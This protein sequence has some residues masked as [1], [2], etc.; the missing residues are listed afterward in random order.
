MGILRAINEFPIKRLNR[1]TLPSN[2]ALRERCEKFRLAPGRA[3]EESGA[4]VFRILAA[5]SAE[6]APSLGSHDLRFI[7]A[8][9]GAHALISTGEVRAILAELKRRREP[10]LMRSAFR[11]LLANYRQ[12]NLRLMLRA[13]VA[14]HFS[15]LPASARRFCEHSGILREDGAIE[16]VCEQITDAA[17]I[18][19]FCLSMGLNSSAL[20]TGYGIEVRLRT[21]RMAVERSEVEELDKLLKWSFE[22]ING[23][24]L[25][26]YYAAVLEPFEMRPPPPDVQKLLMA[27]LVRKFRDPRIHQWPS[28][29]GSEGQS[30][31]AIC[32][33]TIKKWLSIEYLDLF[34]QIIQATAVDAQ[35]NPRKQFWLKYFEKGVISDLTL[36]LANDA[37][38]VALT[39]RGRQQ[40]AE[41]MK[42]SALSQAGSNQS[43]LLMRLGDLIIAEWSHDG[44]MRFWRATD[45]DAPDFHMGEYS[46]R[47]L[48]SGGLRV[49]VSGEYKPAIVHQPNGQWMRWAREAIEYHTGVRV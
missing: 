37:N 49:R 5:F 3:A 10:R 26:D 17:D 24:P 39:A 27:T 13:F 21:L 35:F 11:A 22:G 44:A 32:V 40:G 16:K 18:S 45:P 12:E 38:T 46:A 20:S 15:D 6:E 33:E 43:V 42:W 29:A 7:A 1:L 41:Y 36:I 47:Q 23:V 48:R 8:A 19:V 25:G 14:Q 31:R 30:R 9:I 2:S 28:L 4:R 34:I